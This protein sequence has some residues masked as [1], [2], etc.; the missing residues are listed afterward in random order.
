[1][2]STTEINPE[3]GAHFEHQQ[4]KGIG[5]LDMFAIIGLHADG[6]PFDLA[7]LRSHTIVFE[8]RGEG[9]DAEG[10]KPSAINSLI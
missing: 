4:R 6:H 5:E 9:S 1:M 8:R 10:F 3:C 2:A 7:R